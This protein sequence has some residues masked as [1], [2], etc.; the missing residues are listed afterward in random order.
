MQTYT[1][2]V[3]VTGSLDGSTPLPEIDVFDGNSDPQQLYRATVDSL[4][5]IDL[6]FGG[7][8][9]GYGNRYVPW[10]WIE[11][12]N[13]G[14]PTSSIRIV[15]FT[16]G[17]V[18]N[19]KVVASLAGVSNFYLDT[20]I[21]VG[22]GSM[23]FLDGMTANPGSPITVRFNLQIPETLEDITSIQQVLCCNDRGSLREVTH[24]VITTNA[25][26][27]VPDYVSWV[28]ATMSAAPSDIPNAM[29]ASRAGFI[30]TVE[31][32]SS[33][34]GDF[35]LSLAVNGVV[36]NSLTLSPLPAGS[37]NIS[38]DPTGT[39]SWNVGDLV[40]L[41]VANDHVPEIDYRLSVEIR[42]L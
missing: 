29:V 11:G 6:T 12:P 16:T 34:S 42:Y 35:E 23:L 31:V 37:T 26:I 32:W 14:D 30:P 22:Q 10:I 38:F 33:D 21:L 41:G 20:G 18:R 15:D 19:Q 7:E 4:G 2:D 25:T 9:G 17:V 27:G 28:D 5:L 3:T 24:H 36:V 8:L 1:F 40:S 13:I 39:F